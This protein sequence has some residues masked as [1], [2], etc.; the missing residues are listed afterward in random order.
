MLEGVPSDE[1][2]GVPVNAAL[3]GKEDCIRKDDGRGEGSY[4]QNVRKLIH[5]HT[6]TSKN[7]LKALEWNIMSSPSPTRKTTAHPVQAPVQRTGG[8]APG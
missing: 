4:F 6:R 2:G 7:F 5:T 8:P 1:S 3:K